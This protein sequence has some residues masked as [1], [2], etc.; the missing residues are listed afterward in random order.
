MIKVGKSSQ[1]IS[2]IPVYGY[3]IEFARQKK[4]PTQLPFTFLNLIDL[5]GV[6]VTA[7]I[8]AHMIGVQLAGVCKVVL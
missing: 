2:P 4:N 7:L 8:R 1:K 6:P 3:I 5:T